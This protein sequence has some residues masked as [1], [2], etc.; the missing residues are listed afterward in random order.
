M[1]KRFVGSRSGIVSRQELLKNR[2]GGFSS[3]L[4][5]ARMSSD[6]DDGDEKRPRAGHALGESKLRSVRG[7]RLQANRYVSFAL[8]T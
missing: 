5:C 1:T 2:G 7:F 3:R 6:D 4:E 8:R